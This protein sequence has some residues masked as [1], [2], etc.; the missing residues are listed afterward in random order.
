MQCSI[1][2]KK[3]WGVE[4]QRRENRGA[5]G[6]GLWGGGLRGDN[7]LWQQLVIVIRQWSFLAE[8]FD[9]LPLATN[10]TVLNMHTSE[11]A[12]EEKWSW[13]SLYI[14]GIGLLSRI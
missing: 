10:L 4:R 7:E 11:A 6:E 14:S 1:C 13:A 12:D 2:H 3:Q 9:R 5:E 8:R